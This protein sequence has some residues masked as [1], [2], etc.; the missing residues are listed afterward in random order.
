[1]VATSPDP[2]DVRAHLSMM[3]SVITRMDENSRSCKTW[4][5]TIVA[6]MLVVMA[7]FEI[8]TTDESF[9]LL[10]TWIAVVPATIFW[11]LDAYYLALERGFRDSYD[12]F[13][14]RFRS[15]KLSRDDLFEIRAEHAGRRH[16]L[17]SLCTMSTLPFYSMLGVGIFVAWLVS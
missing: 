14:R 2:E 13:V 15:E 4:A 11:V 3:Q 8:P 6:A 16:F 1:M 5:V 9:G 7:K 12:N 10:E 17:G